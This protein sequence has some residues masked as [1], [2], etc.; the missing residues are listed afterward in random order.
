M[1]SVKQRGPSWRAVVRIPG[2]GK[3]TAT[4]DT[5]AQAR[6]WARSVEG[7][8]A[9]LSLEP[10]QAAGVSVLEL[11]DQF[12][13]VARRQDGGRWNELRLRAFARDEELA[14]LRLGEVSR[15][16]VE[17]WIERR[18]EQ[19]SSRTGEPVKGSTVQ[20]ELN[21]LSSAFQW[22]VTS[23]KWIS[24]NPCHGIGKL[25][26]ARSARR[27]KT[28][29]PEQIQAMCQATG[30][31]M[32]P[33]LRTLSA[34][35][36]AAW[37]LSLETGMRSGEILRARPEHYL[38][39][40]RTLFVAAEERGGRKGSKSGTVD[41]SRMVPL[42]QRAMKLLDQLVATMP[43]DQQPDPAGG[44]ARPP[45]IVGVSDGQRDA[46]FR[47]ARK[48]AG[49]A[50]FTYHDSKHEA[51]TRLCK[52]LDVIQLSHAIGTKDLKL[53][54]DTYYINDASA[55]AALLPASLTNLAVAPQRRAWEDLNP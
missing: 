50:E 44:R 23:R 14:G 35:V 38:R 42:T 43:A 26:G 8:R 17:L 20:R 18:R 36:G 19:P 52:F 5:E 53:L 37:L 33:Q 49:L 24:T 4:F 12:E 22:A 11:L 16:H 3:K 7:R 21:L 31:S 40:Q 28:L 32:D 39:G 54:R 51:C 6:A 41:A 48:L 9:Q 1:A 34:R 10:H 29:T 27:P 45:Y 55:T 15:H 46:L 30:Y 13:S 2:G 47:K 25:P